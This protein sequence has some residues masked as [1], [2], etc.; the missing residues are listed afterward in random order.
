LPC[1]RGATTSPHLLGPDSLHPK[2]PPKKDTDLSTIE[3][4]PLTPEEQAILA[5]TAAHEWQP[6]RWTNIPDGTTV[7]EAMAQ[8]LASLEDLK[9]TRW[10]QESR[11]SHARA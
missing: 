1:L 2:S 10:D 8:Y 7:Q 6:R 3:P 11:A 5:A 4:G 9:Q